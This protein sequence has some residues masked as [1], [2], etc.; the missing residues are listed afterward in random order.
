MHWWLHLGPVQFLNS[1]YYKLPHVCFHEYGNLSTSSIAIHARP[2]AKRG[3][4]MLSVNWFP[5]PE[6][7]Q[8]RCVRIITS[9]YNAHT[10]PLVKQLIILSVPDMLL[11]NSM[12]SYTHKA[13]LMTTTPTRETISGQIECSSI[14]LKNVFGIICRRR[15]ILFQIKF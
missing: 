11:L 10:Q 13:Q 14:S 5:Y 9:T 3:I 4:A 15:L 8:K 1:W 2:K 7:L 6:K 12:K